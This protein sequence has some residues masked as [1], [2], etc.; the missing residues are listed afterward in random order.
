[1]V[2]GRL[3]EPD[4]MVSEPTSDASG[5]T[6][7]SS[8]DDANLWR[9]RFIEEFALAETVVSEGLVF[10]AGVATEGAKS[11]LPH[12]MGQR[13]AALRSVVDMQGPLGREGV[14][15]A[16][17]LD[18]F[19]ELHRLRSFLCHESSTVTVGQDRRWRIVLSL[20]TFRGAEVQRDSMQ[21]DEAFALLNQLRDARVRLDGQLRGM[22]A[23]F[24][25]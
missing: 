10:L 2:T 12:L 25:R 17:A 11:L 6:P 13:F 7:S 14:R 22:L 1:M 4:V 5:R 21:I 23:S 15:V 18:E 24:R 19:K 9:G 3:Y 20:L 8:C 16:S